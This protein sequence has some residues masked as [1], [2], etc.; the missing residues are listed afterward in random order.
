MDKTVARVRRKRGCACVV[1][2]V[3][4]EFPRGFSRAR[5]ARSNRKPAF[6]ESWLLGVKVLAGK[7][8]QMDGVGLG[9]G[10]SENILPIAGVTPL[11]TVD[12]PDCLA[13]V[14]F[15]QGCPWRCPYCHNAALQPVEKGNNRWREIC[16]MLDDRQGFLDAVVFSGGEPTLHA[17]LATAL[18]DVR[19]KGYKV[20]LHTA[21]MFPARL[22]RL[23]Q[24]LDWVG[25]DVKAPFDERSTVLTGDPYSAEKVIESLGI[26]R[27]HGIEHQIRT[28][29]GPG[30][31]QEAD[32]A[33]L[34]EQLNAL[35]FAEP[36]R[37][38]VRQA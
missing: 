34:C 10:G 19:A 17:E 3:S 16:A 1:Y 12:Y 9:R 36:V 24:K 33:D 18:D 29:V 26:L 38:S 31:L 27:E 28:T 6:I 7:V 21:G 11:T 4:L 13:M 30:A 2:V 14:V 32:F 20:G 37:Q 35:G 5:H 8:C 23:V 25:L 15:T 22:R